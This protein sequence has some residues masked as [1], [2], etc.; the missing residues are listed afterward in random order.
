MLE[1]ARNYRSRA[2]NIKRE[3]GQPLDPDEGELLKAAQ[4]RAGKGKKSQRTPV[5]PVEP[6]VRSTERHSRKK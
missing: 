2:A 3:T 5:A 1:D 4:Q 6:R